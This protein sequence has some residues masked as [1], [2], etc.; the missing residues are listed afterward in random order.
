MK[1]IFVAAV[2]VGIF[3]CSKS[4]ISG[5]KDVIAAEPEPT[6]KVVIDPIAEGKSLIEGSDCLGCHKLDE[7]MIG[8]SYK[9]VAAKY[10]NTPE[11]VEMLAEKILK[12]SSGVWGDVPMPAHGF[13]KE[14]AK[15]MAQYILSSK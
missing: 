14:N 9:E 7:K 5:N 12:G 15:F 10:D 3:S 4:E 13:S 11:N 6:P 2:L 1:R 8:P